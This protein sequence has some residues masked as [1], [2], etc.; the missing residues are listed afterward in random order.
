MPYTIYHMPYHTPC[1]VYTT[2]SP[3][4]RQPCTTYHTQ[5]NIHTLPYTIYHVPLSDNILRTILNITHHTY[6]NIAYTIFPT[7]YIYISCMRYIVYVPLVITR[8]ICCNSHDVW[9]TP[10]VIRNIVHA[11]KY[12]TCDTW[13]T[14]YHIWYISTYDS[15]RVCH[16]IRHMMYAILY[17]T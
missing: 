15:C 17:A 7:I 11:V 12:A 14:L 8:C 9:H 2:P 6:Y 13:Y 10:C 1:N 16:D 3:S 5:Y 4:H